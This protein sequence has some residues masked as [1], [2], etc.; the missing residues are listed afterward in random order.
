MDHER[1]GGGASDLW[2]A[3]MH[4]VVHMLRVSYMHAYAQGASELAHTLVVFL[5][6]VESW[7]SLTWAKARS[8]HSRVGLSYNSSSILILLGS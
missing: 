5:L 7:P 8:S 3:Y 2:L 4:G 1:T 6:G